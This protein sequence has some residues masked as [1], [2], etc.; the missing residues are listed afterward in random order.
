MKPPAAEIGGAYSQHD[1][2]LEVLPQSP[3]T[4]A[5][6]RVLHSAATL[7]TPS[8][9]AVVFWKSVTVCSHT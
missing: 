5:S 8:S 2:Q 9:Q 6:V 7:P 3:A 1:A 4:A